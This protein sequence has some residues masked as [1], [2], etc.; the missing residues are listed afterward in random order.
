MIAFVRNPRYIVLFILSFLIELLILV[1]QFAYLAIYGLA[2]T[3]SDFIEMVIGSNTLLIVYYMVCTPMFFFNATIGSYMLFFNR[4][5]GYIFLLFASAIVH[6]ILGG[7]RYQFFLF[8]I[9]LACIFLFK[10]KVALRN[11]RKQRRV[12]MRRMFILLPLVMA[13]VMGVMTII[14]GLRGGNRDLNRTTVQEGYDD[15]LQTIFDYSTVP[16]SALDIVLNQPYA[17]GINTNRHYYG[18]ATF[19]GL[20][21][22]VRIIMFKVFHITIEDV[23]SQ[24]TGAVQTNRIM[25]APD[26]SWNYACTSCLYYYL[27]WG[28]WVCFLIP[29]LLG[30]ICHKCFV[31]LYSPT[32]NIYDICLFTFCAWCMFTSIFAGYVHKMNT[33]PYVV[34]LLWLSRTSNSSK[35]FGRT[36]KGIA[37]IKGL[38][39][40]GAN[41]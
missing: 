15:L 22:F 20:E 29:F 21:N 11:Q 26:K 41:L 14:T 12:T 16:V 2:D 23:Y 27:D 7:G 30:L 17:V 5:W 3:R 19:N 10:N 24:T 35:P 33:V 1:R 37:H 34:L 9:F 18:Q 40:V 6:A 28:I 36:H 25:V 8:V 32:V 31:R 4:K 38:H 13:I 39:T